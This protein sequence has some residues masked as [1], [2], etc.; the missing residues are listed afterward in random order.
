MI[1]SEFCFF[2]CCIDVSSDKSKSRSCKEHSFLTDKADVR[3]MEQSLLQLLDDFHSGKLQ[4]F[5]EW[6][7]VYNTF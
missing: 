7:F 1:L 6:T 5:G 4:A 3:Q 2:V